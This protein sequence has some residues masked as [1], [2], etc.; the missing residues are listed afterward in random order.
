[1]GM[2]G[3]HY[4]VDFLDCRC[5][6][7][8]LNDATEIEAFIVPLVNSSGLTYLY[9]YSYQFY[10][11]DGTTKAGFSTF[12]MLAESHISFHTWSETRK[13][14]CD[15]FAC[16]FTKDNSNS[17]DFIYKF[18]AQYFNSYDPKLTIISRY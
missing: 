14:N 13:V 16:N 3:V 4:I 10:E 12:V 9:H 1:M 15:I 17:V 7:E 2:G 8:R 18:L 11:C 6:M 5:E